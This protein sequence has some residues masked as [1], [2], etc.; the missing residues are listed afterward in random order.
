MNIKTQSQ[1]VTQLL[2]QGWSQSQFP[3]SVSGPQPSL[4]EQGLRATDM[5]WDNVIQGRK[6]IQNTKFIQ[7][8]FFHLHC[9]SR[10]NEVIQT[11][12]CLTLTISLKEATQDL[13]TPIAERYTALVPLTETLQQ[14]VSIQSG[15]N[16]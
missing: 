3:K 6:P 5:K 14:K 13:Y 4:G 1:E 2:S 10:D 11:D 16:Q 12:Y 9:L 7:N 15:T 8:P